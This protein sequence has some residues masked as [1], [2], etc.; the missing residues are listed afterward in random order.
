MATDEMEQALGRTQH[1]TDNHRKGRRVPRGFT[2]GST[3]A[4][5]VC[6][7]ALLAAQGFVIVCGAK[8][9]EWSVW[10]SDELSDWLRNNK[11]KVLRPDYPDHATH[12]F[13]ADFGQRLPEWLGFIGR[14]RTAQPT[15]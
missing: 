4:F 3:S 13:P 5:A 12:A 2:F 14:A 11:A 6:L 1:E 8:E 15:P 7:I 9:N 10:R